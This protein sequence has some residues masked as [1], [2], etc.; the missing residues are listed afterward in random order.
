MSNPY[1]PMVSQYEQLL[2][3]GAQLPLGDIP[4]PRAP[5]IPEGAPTVLLFSPHPDDE[6]IVG[7]LPLR[8]RREL[9]M[10]VINVAVTQGSN[11]ARQRERWGELENACG[12]L[13][14]RLLRTKEDGLE[15]I[16]PTTRAREKETWTA[17][18]NI[19]V[20]I[21][22][23]Q[24]PQ[25]IFIPHEKDANTTHV[26]THFLVLDAL[27]RLPAEFTCLLVE[28]EFWSAIECPNLMI[29]S[30]ARDVADL[31]AATSF[32]VKEVLRN[33]YHL[34]L[35]AWMQDNV[36]RGGELIGG[37]GGAAP[38]FTF[39]TLYRFRKYGNGTL[40][41]ALEAGKMYSKNDDLGELFT[42]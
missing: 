2:R 9:W 30:S 26:G 1:F 10:N 3:D 41:D 33:P 14:F 22:S 40:Q 6:C 24:R 8:L 5:A 21:L 12:F 36:R 38:D 11:K 35:P 39:A 19:I 18:I 25:A 4:R 37:Q 29:E 27:K 17:A 16:K 31:V 28:T 42:R 34:R 20:R 7:G 32:H 23:D 15:D 13:G